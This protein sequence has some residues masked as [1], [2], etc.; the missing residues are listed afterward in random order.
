MIRAIRESARQLTREVE[1]VTD[2]K[3]KVLSEQKKSA[4]MSLGYLK[5][6]EEY[7][8]QSIGVCSQQQVLMSKKQMMERMSQVTQQ[9]NVEEFNPVEKAD[10]QLI[11]DSKVVKGVHHIGDI[12][13]Y[14]ST[15]LQQCKVKEITQIER[16]SRQKK[17]RFHYHWSV[18]I[19]LF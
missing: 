5:D 17:F 1:T 4:E 19:P 11:K 6:C 18:L 2:G 14:S 15:G 12:V 10:V 3:L 16:P 13:F 9:I 8:E 7:V